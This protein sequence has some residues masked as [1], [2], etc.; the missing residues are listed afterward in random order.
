MDWCEWREEDGVWST[1]CGGDF[2][3][4][5]GTPAENRMGFCCYCGKPIIQA[6]EEE[7]KC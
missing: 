6:P 7:E 4:N 5:E 1:D 3:I 2:E